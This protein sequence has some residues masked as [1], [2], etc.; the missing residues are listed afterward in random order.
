MRSTY[1]A[2]LFIQL[3]AEQKGFLDHD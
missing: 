2:K 3:D 1:V